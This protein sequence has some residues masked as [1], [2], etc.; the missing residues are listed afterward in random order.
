ME[1][2]DR[3]FGIR[4]LVCYFARNGH[5]EMLEPQ[6]INPQVEHRAVAR[7][8]VLS[9]QAING[10]RDPQLYTEKRHL[11]ESLAHRLANP[12]VPLEDIA[13]H[14]NLA[15]EPFKEDLQT[16]CDTFQWAAHVL[17]GGNNLKNESKE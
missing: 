3:D 10:A 14:S 9:V 12:D 4:G 16:A 17:G 1:N 7:K 2:M 6:Y 8:L 15:L 11:T 5:E 13:R